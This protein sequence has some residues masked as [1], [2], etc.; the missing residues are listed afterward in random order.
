VRAHLGQPYRCVVMLTAKQE[1]A[2]RTTAMHAGVDVFMSKPLRAEEM[3]AR[4]KMAERI[5]E[6][7]N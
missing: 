7:E 4:L 2:D 1:S 5:L 3:L 6:I